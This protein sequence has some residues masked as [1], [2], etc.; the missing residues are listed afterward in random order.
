MTE[1]IPIRFAQ[2]TDLPEIMTLIH[3][4]PDNMGFKHARCDHKKTATRM[5]NWILDGRVFIL[6]DDAD[7][8]IYGI[9]VLIDADIWWSD[10]EYLS[11]ALTFVRKDKRNLKN[12]NRLLQFSKDFAELEDK[13]LIVDTFGAKASGRGMEELLKRQGFSKV[14]II[15]EM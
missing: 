13:N 1:E 3:S 5:Y 11:S 12:I 8:S 15:A 14:G 2:E 6:V 7:N 4:I 10:A 9:M